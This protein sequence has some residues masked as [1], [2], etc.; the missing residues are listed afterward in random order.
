MESYIKVKA[1]PEQMTMFGNLYCVKRC[2]RI[3]WLGDGKGR[4]LYEVILRHAE[5]AGELRGTYTVQ[6]LMKKFRE[7]AY[8]NFPCYIAGMVSELMEGC[9]LVLDAI[10][11]KQSVTDLINEAL[12]KKGVS[13]KVIN[14]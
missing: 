4:M 2:E 10:G 13:V 8:T 14:E 5:D 3:K 7:D 9:Q 1:T 11:D 12:R 6:T